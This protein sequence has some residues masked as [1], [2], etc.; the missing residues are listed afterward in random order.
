[1]FCYYPFDLSY[2]PVV[3]EPVV[4]LVVHVV[5]YRTSLLRSVTVTLPIH[6]AILFVIEI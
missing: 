2:Y 5:S 1:M 3:P 6:I 4:L